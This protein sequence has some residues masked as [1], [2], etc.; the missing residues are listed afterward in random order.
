MSKNKKWSSIHSKVYIS[1]SLC[2]A[3][4]VINTDEK[5]VLQKLCSKWI[6][7]SGEDTADVM[8]DTAEKMMKASKGVELLDGIHHSCKR[9]HADVEGNK[10]V[11]FKFLKQL[12]ELAE[13]DNDTKPIGEPEARIIRYV[14]RNFGFGTRLSIQLEGNS[15]ELVKN[16]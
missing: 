15:I 7:D 1:M 16:Q 9:I 12:K 13:A 3:D 14:T 6:G 8:R 10:K 5:K 2:V 11:L 4:G